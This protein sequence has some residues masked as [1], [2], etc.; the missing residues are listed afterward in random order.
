MEQLSGNAPD[1]FS[2]ADEVF[3]WFESFTNLEVKTYQLSNRSYRLDRMQFLLELFDHPESA[4]PVFHIAGSKGKGSTATFLAAALTAGGYRTGLYTSPHVTSYRE[5]ITV[6]LQP[7]DDNRILELGNRIKSVIQKINLE[8]VSDYT[9]PTTFELLTLLGLL[10]FREVQC[11]YIVLEVGLGGRL[12]ATNVVL[13]MASL[14]TPIELEHTEILGNTIEEIAFEKAGIIK[15]G[16]PVFSADQHPAAAE[17]IR[18]RAAERQSP[19][20]FIHEKIILSEIR[21]SGAGTQFKL[22]I[23]G[24]KKL[25]LHLRLPGEFQAENAALALLALNSTLPDLPDA[26]IARGFANATLAGRMELMP[27]T[28][29]FVLDGAHTPVSVKKVCRIFKELFP[30]ETICIFGSVKGKKYRE[31]AEIIAPL[32]RHIIISTPGTFKESELEELFAVFH[33]LNTGTGLE[34]SPRKA[35]D[36]ACTLS[37]GKSAVLVTGSFYMVAEIRRIMSD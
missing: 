5:R 20:C 10:Y 1:S 7:P 4:C 9:F 18:V 36:L 14:I 2:C 11:E 33:K 27:G 8:T 17:V 37:A 22:E 29:P 6:S 26:V 30:G 3:A 25:D 15:P 32:F 21:I 13:P 35:Y 31:M 16:I 12:D 28:P 34:K 23:P 24:V 19:L